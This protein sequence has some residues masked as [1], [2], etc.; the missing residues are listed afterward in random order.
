[1]FKIFLIAFSLIL[2][3]GCNEENIDAVPEQKTGFETT[4]A[5]ELVNYQ[6]HQYLGKRLYSGVS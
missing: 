1:M 6:N 5:P 2:I 4:Y 3:S